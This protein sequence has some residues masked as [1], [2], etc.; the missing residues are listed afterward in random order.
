MRLILASASPRRK[1]LLA[2]AGLTFEVRVADV[3]EKVW[4][5][6]SPGNYVQRNAALKAKACMQADELCLGADT[7]VVLDEQILEKPVSHSQA[8][9]ML[10]SLSGR[11]H[12]V[13]TGVCL[14]DQEQSETWLTVTEVEFKELSE[15]EIEKYVATGEPMDKAGA[16]GI[17]SGAAFMVKNISGSYSNV[18]GLP[19]AE[20]I[21][22]LQAY[23]I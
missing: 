2:S 18:V 6:E 5:K 13:I 1:E 3:E 16:Y 4:P 20:C 8:E 9:E 14:C 22:R 7:V 10:R 11:K 17:Q 21:D 15:S 23:G 12:E 19:L